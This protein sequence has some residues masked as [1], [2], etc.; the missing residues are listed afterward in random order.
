MA[1]SEFYTTRTVDGVCVATF[2]QNQILDAVVIER[3]ATSL[4]E[5]LDKTRGGWFVLDFAEVTYLSSSALG[6]LIGL[7][8]RAVQRSAGLKL[9]GISDE[10]MEVFHITKLDTV[11]DI[12]K[13][14]D[15]AVAAY[16]KNF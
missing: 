6:M 10:I 11:F 9:A 8:R 12:Y 15:A 1:A 14:V 13:D 5:L 16:Q 2:R 7:Q 4:K 3:I